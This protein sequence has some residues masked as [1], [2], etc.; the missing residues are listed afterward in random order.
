MM[1]Q[2]Q[3]S[4]KDPIILEHLKIKAEQKVIHELPEQEDPEK[5]EHQRKQFQREHPEL[6]EEEAGT[7]GEAITVNGESIDTKVS[8]RKER[9]ARWFALLR[10][11]RVWGWVIGGVIILYVALGPIPI[12]VDRSLPCVIM[13]HGETYT[14]TIQI[15][16][17]YTWFL[18]RHD[19]FKGTIQTKDSF[20]TVRTID[21]EL[22]ST[23]WTSMDVESYDGQAPETMIQSLE[24]NMDVIYVKGLFSKVLL[25][26]KSEIYLAAPAYTEEEAIALKKQVRPN[27]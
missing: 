3:E 27:W 24:S 4:D 7:I 18:M 14:D 23:F 20:V 25:T 11:F 16:G 22:P 19:R 2:V 9:A 26:Y 8:C 6:Y 17:R 21:I 15:K 13:D 10:W 1:K 12:R 5:E